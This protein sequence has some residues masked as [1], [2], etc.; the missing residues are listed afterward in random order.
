MTPSI[1]KFL[2][3]TTPSKFQ[4]LAD[5]EV[6]A[7][8]PPPSGKQKKGAILGIFSRTCATTL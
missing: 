5:A 1:T 6:L 8:T 2:I 3:H 7:A 4:R